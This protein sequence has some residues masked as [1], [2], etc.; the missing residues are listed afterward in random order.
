MSFAPKGNGLLGA[1]NNGDFANS[2]LKKTL[3]DIFSSQQVCLPVNLPV[4]VVDRVDAGER[5]L[6]WLERPSLGQSCLPR[7]GLLSQGR[8]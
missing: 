7:R 8:A 5:V 2:I 6:V 4:Q 3:A 1:A